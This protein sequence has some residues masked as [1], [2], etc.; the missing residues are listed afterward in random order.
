[1]SRFVT[2]PF[3]LLIAVALVAASCSSDA[4][5]ASDTTAAPSDGATTVATVEA[6]PAPDPAAVPAPAVAGAGEQWSAVAIVGDPLPAMPQGVPVTDPTNDPAIGSFAPQIAGSDFDGTP[7][8]ITADGTPKVIMF[9]AHWCPHCQREVPVVR[10]LIDQGA[11][12]DGLEIILVSTAV[13]DGDPNF[14]PQDWLESESWPGPVMRDS[15]AFEALLA[16]GSGGFPYTVY[17]DGDNRVVGRSAGEL[18][19]DVL[20]QIWLATAEA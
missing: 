1:M 15:T 3:S 13:R 14:P 17:L 11:V 10:D 7:V 9:V 20:Q 2:R 19:T 6:G 12:P 8:T 5:E 4:D 16:M 18:P